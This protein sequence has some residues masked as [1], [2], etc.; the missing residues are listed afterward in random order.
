M[1]EPVNNGVSFG[2]KLGS[3]SYENFNGIAKSDFENSKN[4]ALAESVFS[5]YDTR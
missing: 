4:K 2:K 1:A 5:K 3:V